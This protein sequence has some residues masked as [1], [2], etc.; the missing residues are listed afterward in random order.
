MLQTSAKPLPP[1][2]GTFPASGDGIFI[3]SAKLPLLWGLV[4][5]DRAP[6]M[7]P[8]LG[9]SG[10]IGPIGDNGNLVHHD[11]ASAK[12]P[13]SRGK[14]SVRTDRGIYKNK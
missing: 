2:Q 4:H 7:L 9:G 14:W 10:P 13:P 3:A 1:L 8:L 12:L 5:H 6:A 11:R